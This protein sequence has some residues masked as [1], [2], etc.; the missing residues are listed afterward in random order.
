V[1][2]NS[3]QVIRALLEPYSERRVNIPFTL[4]TNGGGLP[5]PEK[6]EDIN[7]RI[8]LPAADCENQLKLT[9]DHMILCHTPLKD[10]ALLEKYQEKVV[11][12][13]GRYEELNV[14]LFYG[15]KKAIHVEELACFYAD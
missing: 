13:T 8:G 10:P 6:A 1:I 14:A 11:I 15:Y 5:E 3:P 9:G 7:S 4:M 12:V 2:G